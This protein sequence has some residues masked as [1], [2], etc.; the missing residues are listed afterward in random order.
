MKV[1]IVM[2]SGVYRGGAEEALLHLAQA[3]KAA[4]LEL[5]ATFLEPG[6]LPARVAET[7]VPVE[8]LPAGR[9]RQPLA[10]A[11]AVSHLARTFRQEAPRW[12]LS[13]M[14]KG[15]LYAGPAAW[16]AAV[17]AAYFQ[18]GL[19]D[20]GVVDRLC[21]LLPAQGALGCSEFVAARQRAVARHPVLAVPLAADPARFA[22]A[23]EAAPAQLKAAL[24][25]DPACPLIGI[26]GRLQEWKGIHIFAEAFAR[27]LE[28]EP[29][30]Q[31]VVVGGPHHLEPGYAAFLERRVA[32]LGLAGRLRLAGAQSDVGA[33][34]QACDIVVHASREEP[35]GIVVVEAMG[36]GKPVVATGPGGPCEIITPG[37]DGLLV[38]FGDVGALAAALLR[39]LQD[40]TFAATCGAAAQARA[41][42]F[43]PTTLARNLRT[44][45]EAL[46]REVVAKPHPR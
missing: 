13:W 25:F 7:G 12:V 18:M 33:W 35:F 31:G 8:V 39:F 29:G 2:P 43:T 15:H 1:H 9:L 27:V 24:G 4:G 32:E 34:M 22:S 11:R 30:C 36:L 37:K 10:Y 28:V 44:A 20:G 21:R 23:R 19:P 46:E 6:D 42:A 14:T 17:P 38:P 16:R 3:R 40:P 26:V 5:R 41:A 45:L